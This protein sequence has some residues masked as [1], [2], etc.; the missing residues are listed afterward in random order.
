LN[1]RVGKFAEEFVVSWFASEG[2]CVAFGFGAEAPAI[3]DGEYERFW[4]FSHER[5]SVS[6]SN[7]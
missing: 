1:Q 2:D 4:S 6:S 3:E 7:L 5:F